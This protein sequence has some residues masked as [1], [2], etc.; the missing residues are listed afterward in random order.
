V[1]IAHKVS[2]SGSGFDS[3][4]GSTSTSHSDSESAAAPRGGKEKVKSGDQNRKPENPKT[5]T[6]TKTRHAGDGTP[7]PEDFD[8]WSNLRRIT[9]RQEHDGSEES[10]KEQDAWERQL[11]IAR[12]AEF[13]A[14]VAIVTAAAALP[15]APIKQKEGNGEFRAQDGRMIQAFPDD[16]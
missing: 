1:Q 11:A 3:S 2:C 10:R 14:P 4:S 7:W 9:W 16:E 13:L 5:K 15:P 8:S 12:R 6:R